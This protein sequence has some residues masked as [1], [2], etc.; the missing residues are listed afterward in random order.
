MKINPEVDS[1]VTT[2]LLEYMDQ[3][4]SPQLNARMANDIN[5][6]FTFRTHHPRMLVS[7]DQCYYLFE[8]KFQAH[9]FRYLI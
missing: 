6:V 8:I 3:L 2:E 7:V 4:K 9:H 1:E 5:E